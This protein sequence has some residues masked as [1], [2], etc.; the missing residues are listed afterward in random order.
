MPAYADRTLRL[1]M[2]LSLYVGLL[3]T[4]YYIKMSTFLSRNPGIGAVQS[5]DFGTGKKVRDSGSRDCNPYAL[6]QQWIIRYL[7]GLSVFDRILTVVN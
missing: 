7:K 6:G 2:Q 4:L 5:R 3:C 1:R